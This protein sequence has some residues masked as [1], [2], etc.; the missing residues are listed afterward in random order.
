MRRI[1]ALVL[2]LSSGVLISGCG[3]DAGSDTLGSNAKGATAQPASQQEATTKGY[4]LSTVI[5]DRVPIGVCWDMSSAD[6]AR[7]ATERNWSRLAV[8][9]TWEQNSGAQ[10]TGWQQCTNDPN[11]YGIRISVEDIA[12]NGPHTYGLGAMLNNEKGGM[13]LDFTFRNWSPS[14]QGREEYCIRRV[15][16]HE[17]GHALGFAHEQ[18]RPDTPS[19]CTEPAQGTSGDTMIGAWDLASI[20]NY[21]NP[22]WNGDGKLSATDIEMAQK[23]YGPPRVNQTIYTL[24]RAQAPAQVTAYDF[25][26]RAAKATIDLS[27]TG[28]YKQVDRMFPGVDGKR[29]YVLLQRSPTSTDLATID[30]ATNKVLHVTPIGPLLSTVPTGYDIQPALDGTQVYLANGNVVSIIDGD[31]GK[32]LRQIVLPEAYSLVRIATAKNDGGNLYAL[33]NEPGAKVEVLRI[34]LAASFI[35]GGYPGGSVPATSGDQFAVTPDAKKAY[36]VSA[37][38]ANGEGRLTE[39][40]LESGITRV[41]SD[42]P[43]QKPKFLAAISNAQILFADDNGT[44]RSPIILYDV[45]SR[46]KNTLQ[47]S[48]A[49][50]DHVQYD[51]SSQS[52]LLERSGNWSVNQLK[53]GTNGKYRSTD[54]GL[55]S[56]TSG[57]TYSGTAPFVIVAR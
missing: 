24:T 5:W 29:L 33:S 53:Q 39:M 54:L 1:S 22:E 15:A 4:A 25:A 32:L 57:S 30:T 26:S 45:T 20:M 10:F 44:S 47:A 43:E 13:S 18:N 50:P 11:Y 19:T 35:V 56:F 21:C 2:A 8:Q 55:R 14:C 48:S 6:F 38:S 46:A 7:Y 36:F 27:L 3:G 41:L 51:P 49:L 12:T 31:S 17:F 37:A 28:D 16:A 9:E 42:L 23:Y 34:D 40:D 52:I